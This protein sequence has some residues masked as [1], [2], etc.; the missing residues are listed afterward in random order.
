MNSEL[1]IAKLTER[2][3]S[4]LPGLKVQLKMAPLG[5]IMKLTKYLKSNN[6]KRSGVLILLFPKEN[7]L[8]FI[9]TQRHLYEGMHSGQICLPGGK[10]EKIDKDLFHTA[11]RESQEEINADASR[12]KKIGMLSELYVPPSHFSIQ[13]YVGYTDSQ[14]DLK[15]QPE[16]VNE[17]ILTDLFAFISNPLIR[18]KQIP[19]NRKIT[20]SAPYYEIGGYTVWG[21]TAM[22]L[23]EFF[24][25][26]D[27]VLKRDKK[28][29]SLLAK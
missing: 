16:E 14:P 10:Y 22:I 26:A 25:I 24:F 15:K 1:F 20:I 19:T 2:L 28:H 9:L 13:P 4:P 21:A 27:E 3:Q 29:Q 17:I 5:R 23:S 8:F 6:P 7:S 12:I 18:K 11:I